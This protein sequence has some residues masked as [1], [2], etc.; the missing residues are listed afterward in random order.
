MA[1]L[2]ALP[3][4]VAHPL[5][6][7]SAA[8]S[9]VLNFFDAT[10]APQALGSWISLAWLGAERGEQTT[11]PFCR[12]WPTEQAV[13]AAMLIAGAIADGE[14]YPV[15]AWWAAR[16]IPRAARMSPSEWDK[17]TD[18]GWER[19]YARGVAVALGWITGELPDPQAMA[20]AVD[21]SAD[22]IP[23]ADR[24]RHLA[25]LQRISS[26]PGRRSVGGVVV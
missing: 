19:H 17:R 3:D 20:P 18:S 6:A 9:A 26:P 11:G 1:K 22:P 15:P 8:E 2:R 10:R 7:V 16:G 12:E 13:W 25:V 4:W 24:A 21:G 14:V 5:S 23:T